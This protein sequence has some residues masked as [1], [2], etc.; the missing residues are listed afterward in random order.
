MRIWLYKFN[1]AYPMKGYQAKTLLEDR[2]PV[3]GYGNSQDDAITNLVQKVKDYY[4][5]YECVQEYNIVVS[6]DNWNYKEKDV[7]HV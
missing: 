7:V 6:N 5:T 1:T 2:T 3:F 4:D